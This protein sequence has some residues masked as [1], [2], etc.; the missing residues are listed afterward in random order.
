MEIDRNIFILNLSQ[1]KDLIKKRV[2]DVDG[3]NRVF[4]KRNG[5][6]NR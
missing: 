1:K 3:K 6:G 5:N 2:F 4:S